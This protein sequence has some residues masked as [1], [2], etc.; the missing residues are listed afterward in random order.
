MIMIDPKECP[1]IAENDALFNIP[2]KGTGKY[3][4]LRKNIKA[5]KNKEK[6]KVNKKLMELAEENFANAGYSQHGAR[7]LAYL[8]VSDENVDRT[9]SIEFINLC[10]IKYEFILKLQEAIVNEFNDWRVIIHKYEIG[11]SIAVYKNAI[12]IK[13]DKKQRYTKEEF[14][15][16]ILEAQ[17]IRLKKDIYLQVQ[18][19]FIDLNINNYLG[20]IKERGDVE[21]IVFDNHKGDF[22]K[23]TVLTLYK[24]EKEYFTCVAKSDE[25]SY[26]DSISIYNKKVNNLIYNRL[27]VKKADFFM[28]RWVVPKNIDMPVEFIVGY[29]ETSGLNKIEIDLNNVKIIKHQNLIKEIEVPLNKVYLC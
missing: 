10:D 23:V 20:L 7:L 8:G 3:L 25:V 16:H 13:E 11:E 22:S 24:S 28:E 5:L 15:E 19:E 27:G 9:A 26:S 21:F 2:K 18:N 1:T 14:N 17:K 4:L 6:S 12:R 29:K